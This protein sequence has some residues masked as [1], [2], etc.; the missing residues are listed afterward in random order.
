MKIKDMS[1]VIDVLEKY[2]FWNLKKLQECSKILRLQ[3]FG[4]KMFQNIPVSLQL[5]RQTIDREACHPA[6]SVFLQTGTHFLHMGSV[7]QRNCFVDLVK[8]PSYQKNRFLFI[9]SSKKRKKSILSVLGAFG[10]YGGSM[11]QA[12]IKNASVGGRIVSN[13]A[14][15]LLTPLRAFWGNLWVARPLNEP[16]YL[17]QTPPRRPPV[18]GPP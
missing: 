3:R 11:S 15:R 17:L 10:S 7:D 13:S 8:T 9:F 2:S 12:R 4:P 16:L 6:T 18:L 5:A 1:Y 14:E